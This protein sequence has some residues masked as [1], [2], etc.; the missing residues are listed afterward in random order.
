M[1]LA[2]LQTPAP[3]DSA[4]ELKNLVEHC[5]KWD[6]VYGYDARSLYPELIEIKP[7]NNYS[8][9]KAINYLE[10]IPLLV[11]KIQIMQ[12]EID[13]L[14]EKMNISSEK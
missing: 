3:E 9:I 13:E 5:K 8:K 14:K 11:N 6:Q 12:K 2:V 10:I 7:D 4:A 1:C